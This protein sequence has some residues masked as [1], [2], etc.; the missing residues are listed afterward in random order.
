MVGMATISTNDEIEMMLVGV[1][2]AGW[3]MSVHATIKA[4]RR[5]RTHSALTHHALPHRAQTHV[6]RETPIKKKGKRTG[7]PFMREVRLPFGRVYVQLMQDRLGEGA[8]LLLWGKN[9]PIAQLKGAKR[10]GRQRLAAIIG[11]P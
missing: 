7:K 11:Q 3:G 4:I 2:R 1:Y 9:V 6:G 5:F 8:P 10:E